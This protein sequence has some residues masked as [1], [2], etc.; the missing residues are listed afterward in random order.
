MSYTEVSTVSRFSFRTKA[1]VSLAVIAAIIA[2][3]TIIILTGKD[4][5]PTRLNVPPL[6][7]P[8]Q[9][10]APEGF[11][12]T[13]ARMRQLQTDFSF[14]G[15]VKDRFFKSQ[16]P[17]S[18]Y[19]LLDRIDTRTRELNQRATAL[20]GTECLTAEPIEVDI[21]GWPGEDLTM[22]AQ[23]HDQLSESLFMMFGVRNN[24]VY[25]YEKDSMVTILAYGEINPTNV[26]TF[27]KVDIYFAV[28]GAYTAAQTGSRG[29]MHLEALPE[30]NHIQA[31][32]AGI[33]MGFCGVEL[34]SDGDNIKI[35]GS[36]DGVGGA[37]EDVETICISGDLEIVRTG[38]ECDGL[39]N[40]LGSLGRK[41]SGDFKGE[42]NITEWAASDFPGDGG[43]NVEISD[44]TTA[45]VK[46]GPSTPP[47]S[48]SG[49]LFGE[50]N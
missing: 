37:C 22:W 19:P 18:I 50:P 9:A 14:H 33:G 6:K 47:P 24:T 23:C 34:V 8:V 5:G 26:T 1:I 13:A 42:L 28:G 49:R 38:T 11:K 43:N 39:I 48:M 15:Q 27:S 30:E 16:G 45:H 21:P 12:V 20:V 41:V 46:F 4:D 17:S 35:H 10:A 36:Q 44:V 2:T 32:M 25:L 31:S 40:D 7:P 29:L 3:P